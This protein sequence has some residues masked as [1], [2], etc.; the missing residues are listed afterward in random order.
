VRVY[1][2]NYIG[3]YIP[4]IPKWMAVTARYEGAAVYM[5]LSLV[6]EDSWTE[7]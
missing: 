1:F 7:F 2:Y 5:L 4:A 3:F 6:D